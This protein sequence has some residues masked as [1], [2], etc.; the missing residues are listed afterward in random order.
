MMDLDEVKRYLFNEYKVYSHRKEHFDRNDNEI[1]STYESGRM[2]VV[3]STLCFIYQVDSKEMEKIYEEHFN[4]CFVFDP[5]AGYENEDVLLKG[6]FVEL[7]EDV[8]YCP[9]EDAILDWEES[10]ESLLDDGFKIEDGDVIIPKGTI[11]K[12]MGTG[13]TPGSWPEFK[14]RMKYTDYDVD[15]AGDPF[16]IKL[17]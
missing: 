5:S 14:L 3:W 15:F 2:D 1:D 7:L 8:N 13:T 6:R 16:K 10:E 12:Y 11:M 17:L 4:P 9:L